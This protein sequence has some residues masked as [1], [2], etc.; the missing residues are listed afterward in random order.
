MQALGTMEELP[1]DYL[2]SLYSQNLYPLWPSLRAMLPPGK[3]TAKTLPSIWR[4]E[5]LK[6]LLLKAGELTPIERAERRVLVLSNPGH[7]LS[8]MQATPVMYLG[9]QLILPGEVAPNHRHTPNAVRIVVEGEGAYTGVN[10]ERCRM[11]R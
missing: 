8:N 1:E 2:Q 10:G 7:G 3:P 4:Y 9:M 6:P 11:E 5:A